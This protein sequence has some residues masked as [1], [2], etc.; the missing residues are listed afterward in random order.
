M[1]SVPKKNTAHKKLPVVCKITLFFAVIGIIAGCVTG[2]LLK[3]N[4]YSPLITIY[5]ETINNIPGLDIDKSDIFLLAVKRNVKLFIFLYLFSLTNLW[6]YYYCAF[7][8]YTGFTNG[9]L[10]AFNIILHGIPGIVR[11][12]CY[13]CPQV[14]VFIPVYLAIIA[15]CDKLHN[16]FILCVSDYPYENTYSYSPKQKKGKLALQQFPFIVLCLVLIAAGSFIEAH[17]NLPLVIWYMGHLV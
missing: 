16:E 3:E 11:F 6:T 13:L 17:L 7:S 2:H 8:L 1:K 9:L 5:N 10:L 12:L 15:H 4:L 14:L